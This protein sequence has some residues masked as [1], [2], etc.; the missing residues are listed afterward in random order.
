MH[1]QVAYAGGIMKTRSCRYGDA[2]ITLRFPVARRD[3]VDTES[4]R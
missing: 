3:A 1:E 4:V 2:R